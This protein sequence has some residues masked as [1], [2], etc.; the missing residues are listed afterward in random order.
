MIVIIFV[1]FLLWLGVYKWLGQWE[2][3]QGLFIFPPLFGL[4]L[5]VAWE[6][7]NTK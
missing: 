7:M 4:F 5:F 1:L 6:V 2:G 3:A